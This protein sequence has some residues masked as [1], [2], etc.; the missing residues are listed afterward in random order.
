MGDRATVERVREVEASADR[1]DR[2]LWRELADAG[3]LGI[4]L[5][6]EHGGSGLGL[7]EL[8]LVLEEQGR[9]VAPVPLL[10]SSLA[11]LA[12]LERGSD[13]ERAAWLP[14]LAS[15]DAVLTIA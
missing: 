4:F 9:V 15:G 14:R 10:W 12:I 5:P 13:D 8:G 6:E 2:D 11:A 1:F 3:L 7:I